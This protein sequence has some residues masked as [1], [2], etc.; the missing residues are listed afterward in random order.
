MPGVAAT[1]KVSDMTAGELRDLIQDTVGSMIDP[2]YG[3][4]LRPEIERELQESLAQKEE[5]KLYS[6]A[7]VKALLGL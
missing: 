6:T 1:K 3:L 5:G 2:D 7:E 4:E